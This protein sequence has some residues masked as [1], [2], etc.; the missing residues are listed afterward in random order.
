M[1]VSMP[2]TAAVL[3]EVANVLRADSAT[4]LTN[5]R[6]TVHIMLLNVTNIDLLLTTTDSLVSGEGS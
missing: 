2:H 4:E 3:V 1:H 6:L 5:F